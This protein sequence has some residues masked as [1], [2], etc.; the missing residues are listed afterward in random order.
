MNAG[1]YVHV[2]GLRLRAPSL[3]RRCGEGKGS[4]SCRN[5]VCELRVT[6]PGP[7]AETTSSGRQADGVPF[8]RHSHDIEPSPSLTATCA[9]VL[10]QLCATTYSRSILIRCAH[11]TCQGCHQLRWQLTSLRH[12]RTGCLGSAIF[13]F[14][15]AA[16][17]PARVDEQ[18][19]QLSYLNMS[20]GLTHPDV[21]W[22]H[23]TG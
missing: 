2:L 6:C 15:D 16:R 18:H 23:P 5:R 17:A 3:L 13:G 1:D 12:S 8:V 9:S 11:W 20:L 22:L 7:S 21:D 19:A 14:M 10:V 4:V